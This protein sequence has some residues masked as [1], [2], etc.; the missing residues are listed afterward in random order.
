MRRLAAIF[1]VATE[2][3]GV[4]PGNRNT[5]ASP[6]YVER[7][8]PIAQALH[9]LTALLML[10]AVVLAWI[11]MAMPDT[12]GDRFTYITL[13]KSVGQTIFLLAVFR[14]FWRKRHPPPLMAG[15]LA[16]WE[17]RAARWNHWLLYGIMILMP[18]S[19]YILATA[20]ARPSPYFWLFYW[21]QPPLVPA[22]AHAALRIHLIG[23]FLV[24]AFVGIHILG[25]GWHVAMRR[26]A[27]LD[28]MLP[29]QTARPAGS[30]NVDRPAI[31]E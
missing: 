27:T 8:T 17:A 28:R 22:L 11:F 4:S 25:A 10:V 15:R 2:R 14:L 7:Y 16:Q 24:Y 18:V 19:G 26:D 13:H 29:S 6:D 3:E 31:S 21:P 20:A 23:Q 30:A 1:A 5:S 9:W 12:V